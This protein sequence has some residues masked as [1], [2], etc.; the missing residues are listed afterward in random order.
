MYYNVTL[1]NNLVTTVAGEKQHLLHILSVSAALVIQH[2]NPHAP[3]FIAIRGHSDFTVFFRI[4]SST[5]Q[6][7]KKKNIKVIYHEF[8][9]LIFLYNICPKNF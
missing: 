9:V 5:A 6:F 7:S 2:E 3:R 8:R 1:R 4:I